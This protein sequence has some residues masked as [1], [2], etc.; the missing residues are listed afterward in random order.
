[1]TGPTMP[2]PRRVALRNI[3]MMMR[4]GFTRHR[5]ALAVTVAAESAA[6]VLATGDQHEATWLHE[7][8]EHACHELSL[9]LRSEIHA[10]AH[11]TPGGS[12]T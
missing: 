1:M 12:T 3:A 7:I 8:A 6:Q 10:A 5:S 11:R 4:A 2:D 9:E